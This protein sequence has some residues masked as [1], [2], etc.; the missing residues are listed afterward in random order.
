MAET[1]ILNAETRDLTGKKVKQLRAHDLVPVVLYGHG[2]KSQNLS[3]ARG[4]FEKVYRKAGGSAVVTIKMA[5]G[6]HTALIHDVQDDPRTGR[7][8]HADLFQVRMDEKIK[9]E[10]PLT[11]EGESKAVREEDGVLVTNLNEVEVE[12][13]PGD[14]PSEIVVSLESLETF[15]DSISVADLKVAEGVEI[16]NEADTNVAAVQPPKTEEQLEAELAEDE[17]EGGEPEVIGEGEE[18]EEGEGGEGGDEAAEGGDEKAD[19]SGKDDKKE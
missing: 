16:L 19:D 4:E 14:L 7:H 6:E 12:C 8:L 11:F 9:A 3:V 10:V 17:G 15:E 5:D 2:I 1:Y 18:G 13:L